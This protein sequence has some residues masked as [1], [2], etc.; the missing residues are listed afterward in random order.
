M[1]SDRVP[2][3][4]STRVPSQ[5]AEAG[6]EAA[7]QTPGRTALA[8]FSRRAFVAGLPLLAAAC[9]SRPASYDIRTDPRYIAAY[10]PMPNE[11]FPI[12]AVNIARIEPQFLR[13][14]VDFTGDE[15][16]GTI[17]IETEHRFLYLVLEPGKAL[18]YGI[19]VGKEGM[20]FRGRAVI[21][22]KAEWPNW[23]PTR[24]MMALNPDLRAYAGGMGPGLGNP[25]GARALYLAR[26]GR[27]TNYRIHGT[28]EPWTI[29]HAVSSGCIRMINQDVID[30]YN[31]VPVGTKVVVLE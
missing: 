25:L 23:T 6:A 16:P 17:V 21:G 13:R 7:S 14:V 29:G 26:G 15:A 4:M 31:R 2:A 28:N 22:R 30:L 1:K 18:R 9:I 24:N 10:G 11:R 12:P 8:A 27:E 5:P 20:A 19:G 3:D